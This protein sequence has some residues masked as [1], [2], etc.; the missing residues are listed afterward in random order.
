MVTPTIQVWHIGSRGGYT[1]FEPSESLKKSVF[2][3]FFDHSSAAPDET[4]AY[5]EHE[6]EFRFVEQIFWKNCTNAVFYS[7][8]CPY[9]SGL[10]K[11]RPEFADWYVYGNPN[12][13][14]VLG[15]A[16]RVVS[17][18][19]IQTATVDLFSEKDEERRLP[20][21]LVI[22]AQGSSFEIL[23]GAQKTLDGNIDFV[24][25][26]V[27]LAAFFDEVPSFVKIL[28]FLTEKRFLFAYFL[29]E[30]NP[31]ASPVRCPIGQRSAPFMGSADAVFLRDPNAIIATT[32][33]VRI[34]RYIIC[35]LFLGFI[36][37]ACF[38]SKF[39]MPS[40]LKGKL[41]APL[42]QCLTELV[43]ALQ[44]M[45][46]SFGPTLLGVADRD[47]RLAPLLSQ[48]SKS[49]LELFLDRW[50]MPKWS[51]ATQH[52]RIE[53]ACNRGPNT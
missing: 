29:D 16:C 34:G 42:V 23:E 45:P 4:E 1:P 36:E 10:K 11:L 30:N 21:V 41:A 18:H 44:S 37:Q 27:E 13:D 43:S 35:C 5:S 50:S 46:K 2:I 15:D 47:A 26:E 22:D 33:S 9:A 49:S 3:T 31:W 25:A 38:V 7:T 19:N 8:L 53:Q 48:T 24:I 51:A 52:R 39:I 28:P 6:S 40:E 12:L 20:T 32:D 14:Y 17:T